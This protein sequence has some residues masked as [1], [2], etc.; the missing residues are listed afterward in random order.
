MMILGYIAD[1]FIDTHNVNDDKII[2]VR[3]VMM[4]IIMR[5]IRKQMRRIISAYHAIC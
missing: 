4:M 1:D 3:I 5:R 2:V